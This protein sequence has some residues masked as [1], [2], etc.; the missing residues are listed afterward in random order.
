MAVR[1]LTVLNMLK[2]PSIHQSN[3]FWGHEDAG[4]YLI[5]FWVRTGCTQ[6]RSPVCHRAKHVTGSK[7]TFKQ[8]KLQ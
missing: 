7:K 5:Y 6:D 8:D 1:T 3:C 4:A 2:Y